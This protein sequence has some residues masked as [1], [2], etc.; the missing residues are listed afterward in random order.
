M[1]AATAATGRERPT[2]KLL[3]EIAEYVARPIASTTAFTAALHCLMDSLGVAMLAMRYPEC[4]KLLGPVVGGTAVPGG[5]AVP[6]TSH[7]LDPV[8]AAFDI[9]CAIRWLDYN[10]TF[11]AA[12]WGHP[13]DNFGAILA[14][15]SFETQ[16]RA[17]RGEPPIGVRQVLEAA[18]KAYEIQGVL[19]LENAFNR[20]GIDHVILV[21]VASTAVATWLLGGS[22]QQVVDAVSNAWLDGGALRTYRQAPNT[23]SRKSWAAGDATSRGVQ[24]G[25]MTMAGEMGY[26]RALTTPDWGFEDVVMGGNPVIVPQPFGT[27]V[28]ENIL[29]K[30][31]YPAEFHGQTALEAAI[32]LHPQVRQRLDQIDLIEIETQ[33]AGQRIIDKRGELANPA[34]R[35]HCIQY[36]VAVGLIWGTL[37]SDHYEATTA[38]DPRVDAL[39]ARTIVRERSAFTRDYLDPAKRSIA[40]SVQVTF[41]DGSRTESVLVEYPLGHPRRRAEALPV[42]RQ[43]FQT[44]LS[45]HLPTRTV[46]R[47]TSE[48]DDESMLDASIHDVLA[49]FVSDP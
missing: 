33:E 23:G 11:L 18:I 39:R 26:P 13:S 30:V 44:N 46:D 31:S 25:L 34:D 2:D 48:F 21:R 15:A 12:E 9:G 8:K 10:D 17:I 28:I 38:A 37:T 14:T 36:M 5:V 41:T 1:T 4:T 19:S 6:G 16:R 43:K 42:L 22:R 40:N 20:I 29:F 3:A 49:L 35:D 24:L 47:I 7:V 32:A 27:Y 45:A